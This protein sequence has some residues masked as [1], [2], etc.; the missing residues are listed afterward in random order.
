M[1]LKAF[2]RESLDQIIEAVA[3]SAKVADKQ[4]AV[5]NPRQR[6]FRYGHGIYFDKQTGS[7]LVNV[8][9]DIA[10]TV[11]DQKKSKG[12]IGVA[13]ANVVLGSQGESGMQNERLNRIKFSV[14]V[15]L[16]SSGE[17]V[18]GPAAEE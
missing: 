14:P 17:E 1:E 12:G 6:Q 7:P 4:G 2:I 15:V 3:A 16:P 5:I 9:F 8:E 13:M 18:D 11:A 10:V